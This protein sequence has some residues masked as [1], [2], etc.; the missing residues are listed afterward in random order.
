MAIK[1]IITPSQILS[2]KKWDTFQNS[3][4]TNSVKSFTFDQKEV[5]SRGRHLEFLRE[6]KVDS[7]GLLVRYYR[8]MLNTF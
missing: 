8:D 2:I 4:V 6:P 1:I 3:F 5:V 7:R